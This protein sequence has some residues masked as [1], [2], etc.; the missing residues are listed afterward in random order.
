M[1]LG[2]A[3]ALMGFA[4]AQVYFNVLYDAPFFTSEGPQP[5]NV[6][7]A[8]DATLIASGLIVAVAVLVEAADAWRLARALNPGDNAPIGEGSEVSPAAD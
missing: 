1:L 7:S 2:P 3:I 4:L 5:P 8:V 6:R